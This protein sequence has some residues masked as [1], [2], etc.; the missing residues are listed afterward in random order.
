M[1]NFNYGYQTWIG[2][3]RDSFLF[4]GM[5]GQNVLGF[6]DN[7]ILLLVNSGND[8]FFQQSHFFSL[9]EEYFPA[10]LGRGGALNVNL[11]A[12]QQL[13][14]VKAWLVQ[15]IQSAVNTWL[16]KLAFESRVDVKGCFAALDGT[17]LMPQPEDAAALGILPLLTQM[18]QNNF[19]QGLKSLSFQ[20]VDGE[21]QLTVNEADESHRLPIGLDQPL[22][23]DLVSH[24]EH[25]RV[26]VSGR[27]TTDE[28]DNPVLKIRVSFLEI[29]NTRLIKL[30][31]R[32][33]SVVADWQETP[34]KPFFEY[35]L[36][37]VKD[38]IRTHPI[39]QALLEKADNDYMRF[40]I[41][42]CIESTIHFDIVN[43]I[44][45]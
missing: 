22:M 29:A 44:Q 40:R 39:A 15:P 5:F 8:E 11:S 26:A 12:G 18:V 38:K 13:Q 33:G 31:F 28:D 16:Q 37:Q 23:T 27:L 9:S 20:I 17:V 30:H 19:T 24:G 14:N 2:R 25:Y 35:T 41:N 10:D 21:L 32:R 43:S 7:G 45:S 6:R 4:N 1:G 34:G 36:E 42:R 3:Q